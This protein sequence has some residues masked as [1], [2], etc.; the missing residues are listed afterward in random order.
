MIAAVR[1]ITGFAVAVLLTSGAYF[2][3]KFVGGGA[4]AVELEGELTQNERIFLEDVI[5]K[6]VS[7]SG[8]WVSSWDI[9]QAVDDVSWTESVEVMR[10]ITNNLRVKV[11]RKNIVAMLNENELL[12]DSGEIISIPD[13]PSSNLPLVR[14]S[15]NEKAM[16]DVVPIF[17]RIREKLTQYDESISVLN[18]TSE[19][20][21]ITLNSGARVVLGNQD[22][23]ARMDRFLAVYREMDEADLSL[24]DADARYDFG[25]AVGQRSSSQIAK[26]DTDAEVAQEPVVLTYE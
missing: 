12:T 9:A 7:E 15:Q 19:G 18:E 25:V 5:E 10:T 21:K 16:E 4:L 17:N 13:E 23:E 3:T 26:F 11:A 2:T 14:V 8:D 24:I 20:W 6:V 1:F 22:Y